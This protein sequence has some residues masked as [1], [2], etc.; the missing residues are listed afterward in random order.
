M[1][2]WACSPNEMLLIRPEGWSGVVQVGVRTGHQGP[3]REALTEFARL[4]VWPD[5]AT[6]L[7]EC[8]QASFHQGISSTLALDCFLKIAALVKM[9]Q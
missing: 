3:G 5:G 9:M 2:R 6:S 8:R 1:Y 4:A 7:V